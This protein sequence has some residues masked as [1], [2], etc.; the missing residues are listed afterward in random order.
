MQPENDGSV[1]DR[2]QRVQPGGNRLAD[3]V[4]LH[5]ALQ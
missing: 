5:P 2:F 1:V 3:R 4:T